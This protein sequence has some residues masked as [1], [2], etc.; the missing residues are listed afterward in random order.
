MFYFGLRKMYIVLKKMSNNIVCIFFLSVITISLSAQQDTG[1]I[2]HKSQTNTMYKIIEFQ[3]EGAILRG[4][5][6]LPE[7]KSENLAIIIMAHGF[8]ATI[9]GMV[10]DRYAEV[11]CEDGFAVLLYDHRNLG[12]SGGEPRQQINK[13]I[14]ARGYRDAIDFVTTL[15]EIDTSKI[16][17]WGDSMSGGEVIVVAAIDHR[18]KAIVAQ[19]PLCGGELPPSDPDGKLYKSISDTFLHGDVEGTPETTIGPM[20]VVSFDQNTIPSIL[21]PLTAY[22]WFIEYGGRYNT[23]WE[24]SITRIEPDVPV[25]F[26]PVLCIPY[27]KAA[28]LMVV[29]HDDEMVGRANS[30]VSRH[31]YEI[32]PHPKKFVEV[33]GGHFGIIHYPSPLFDEASQAQVDFLTEHLK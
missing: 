6:Y 23:K 31:A 16:G 3:S 20:P 9:E 32:A 5:L 8:S 18:V 29:A 1:F 19:V 15:P 17:L 24:N 14:Q 33:D 7:N 21:T 22:R 27:I 28:L 13:W 10:A 2:T 12:I 4:R 11:F 25:K 26:N 30:E